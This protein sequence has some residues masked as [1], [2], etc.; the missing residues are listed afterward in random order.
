MIVVPEVSRSLNIVVPIDLYV[1]CL[2]GGDHKISRDVF[3]EERV[4]LIIAQRLE[5]HSKLGAA[6]IHA[7]DP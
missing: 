3:V 4:I 7:A 1:A 2:V 6:W 5:S